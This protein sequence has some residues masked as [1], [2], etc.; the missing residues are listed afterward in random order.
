MA[1]E[2]HASREVVAEETNG[3]R[4]A[5]IDPIIAFKRSWSCLIQ[6]SY[7]GFGTTVMESAVVVSGGTIVGGGHGFEPST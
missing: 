1:S 4:V 7:A 6:W 5:E 3:T 2:G